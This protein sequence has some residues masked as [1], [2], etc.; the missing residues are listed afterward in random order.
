MNILFMTIAYPKTDEQNLYSDLMREFV[1][2]GHRLYVACTSERHNEQETKLT[3]ENGSSILRVRTGN[4]TGRVSLIEKGYT[5]ITLEYVIKR[6]IKEHFKKI[7]F[8]LIVYS[9]PP[10]TFVQAVDYFKK[11]DNA[12]T[13]LLLK[14]I[15]PQNAVDIGLMNENG[16]MHKYFRAKEKS[17]YQVSDYIG[18][19]SQA[20]VDY[21]L[22][23]N[24]FVKEDKIEVCPNSIE[25]LDININAVDKKNIRN[26]YGIPEDK[27]VF[28]YGGNLGKP[29][30]IDFLMQCLKANENNNEAFIVIAGSGTE[31][32]RL[33]E[34]FDK[35]GLKNSKLFSHIP[36]ED[37]DLLVNTCDVGLIFLDNRFTIPNFPSRLL[38]YMQASIPVLAFTDRSTDIGKVI[39][40]GEFGYW[41]ESG[42][43][44]GFRRNIALMCSDPELRETMGI[45]ARRYLEDNYT[46]KHSYDIIMK[47]FIWG[48]VFYV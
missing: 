17:L 23:H 46:V 37:Y 28:I 32:E 34:F 13:Y 48:R 29:Q 6:A 35:E 24:P 5:T 9:T 40:E 15:F 1:R 14:D 20:N 22:K 21:I 38:S 18:C 3:V 41:S 7:K 2:R 36:K 45:N 44:K 43:L 31:Y 4:L 11:R 42:D 30:G 33:E 8:D 27:T 10:I 16:L 19:M 39:E 26:K 25:P 12:R 47:H